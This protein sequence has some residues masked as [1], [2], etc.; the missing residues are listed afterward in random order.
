MQNARQTKLTDY[1]N[2]SHGEEPPGRNVC[3]FSAPCVI[4]YM[5]TFVCIINHLCDSCLHITIACNISVVQI[6]AHGSK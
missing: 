2:S 1:L 3:R 4:L 6:I 5:C